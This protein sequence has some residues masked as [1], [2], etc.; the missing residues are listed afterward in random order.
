M[1]GKLAFKYYLLIT[2]LDRVLD[3]IKREF[4]PFNFY[5]DDISIESRYISGYNF[6]LLLCEKI[7]HGIRYYYV[8]D[9]FAVLNDM[10][11]CLGYNFF[12]CTVSD[13][14]HGFKSEIN[15]NYLDEALTVEEIN[16]IR[17][18]I[19]AILMDICKK[20]DTINKLLKAW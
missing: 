16:S 13:I 18:S 9:G 7:H 17:S 1:S 12:L 8:Y 20:D 3:S 19:G 6:P 11:D 2:F 15:G 5:L 10:K 14:S 4:K